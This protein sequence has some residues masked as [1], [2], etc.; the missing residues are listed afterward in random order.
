VTPGELDQ[1]RRLIAPISNRTKNMIARSVVQLVNDGKK[2]QLVQLGVLFGETVEGDGQGVEH[3]QPYGFSSVPLEGAEGVVVFAGADRA[4][5][6]LIVTSD[7]RYRPVGGQSGEVTVYNNTGAKIVMT[8][9]GD[10]VAT[11]APGRQVMIDDGTGGLDPLVKRSEFLSHGHATAA[12][13]PVSPPIV[14]PSSTP[15]A[16]FPGTTLLVTK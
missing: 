6:L 16:T 8:K 10:I 13:G 3:F 11:P 15:A 7:R 14:A 2:L 12:T 1:V 9:D 4:H 5:P